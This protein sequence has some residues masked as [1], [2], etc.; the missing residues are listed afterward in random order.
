V[1]ATYPNGKVTADAWDFLLGT[2]LADPNM[3]MV[4]GL[5]RQSVYGSAQAGDAQ[6][7]VVVDDDVSFVVGGRHIPGLTMGSL[8]SL[9]VKVLA[10]L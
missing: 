5:G 4:S 1:F 6:L 8:R 3:T 9:A 7:W 10:G 2:A